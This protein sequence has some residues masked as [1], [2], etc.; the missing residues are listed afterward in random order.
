MMG[1]SLLNLKN[2]RLSKKVFYKMFITFFAGISIPLTCIG[3]LSIEESSDNVIKQVNHSTRSILQEKEHLIDQ[4][5]VQVDKTI[6]QIITNKLVWNDV[7]SNSNTSLIEYNMDIVDIADLLKKSSMENKIIDSIYI[8][9]TNHDFVIYDTKY[10]KDDFFDSEVLKINID[11][12]YQAILRE[13]HNKRQNKGEKVIT[14]IKQFYNYVYENHISIIANVNYDLL[15]GG[16]LPDDPDYPLDTMVFD[17]KQNLIFINSRS[18]SS[19][20]AEAFK[21][22]LTNETDSYKSRINGTEYYIN[23]IR[24]DYLDW[25]IVYAQ[26]YS[27]IVQSTRLIRDMITYSLLIA[28]ALA[29]LLAYVFSAYLYKPLGKLMLSIGKFSDYELIKKGVNEYKIINESV[30]RLF[31]LKNDLNIK[32]NLTLPYFQLHSISRFLSS[33]DFDVKEFENVLN[34]LDISFIYSGYAVVLVDLENAECTEKTKDFFDN[35]L[36]GNKNDMVYVLSE[37][38]NRRMAIIINTDN[39]VKALYKSMR[40]LKEYFD[41][42]KYC[43]TISIGG[44]HESLEKIK[45]SYIEALRKLEN[46]FFMGK[47]DIIICGDDYK[48]GESYSYDKNIEEELLNSIRGQNLQKAVRLLDDL[49]NSLGENTGTIEYVKYIYFQLLSNIANMIIDI[50]IKHENEVMANKDVFEKIQHSET[51]GDLQKFVRAFVED[52][53]SHVCTLKKTQHDYIVGKTKEFIG[54]N[55]FKDLSLNEIANYVFLSPRYL[56][57]I[58]KEIVG[59]TIYDYITKVRI[60]AARELIL[61]ENITIKNIAGM[62][63]YNNSHTFIR[64]FVKYNNVTPTQFRRKY[65]LADNTGP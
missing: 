41:G 22:T 31:N 23:K 6:N 14:Y 59:T 43:L 40:N 1:F 64:M 5:I 30:S 28:L 2:K 48:T 46:K 17:G 26:S 62:V 32:Y 10:K 53:V 13:V 33:K 34:I 58:F 52:A 7:L 20:G 21:K 37:I 65:Y 24:Y 45:L 27:S 56:N 47:N 4:R 29:M 19:T 61:N 8:F 55:Y 12:K 44:I 42:M 9:D 54:L 3:I 18:I 49:I 35:G 36:K 38:S 60:D 25:T 50:G 15:F 57:N 63:G 51:L 11:G 39:D 16:L